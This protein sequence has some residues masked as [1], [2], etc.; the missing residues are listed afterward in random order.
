PKLD[1][2]AAI[3]LSNGLAPHLSEKATATGLASDGDSYQATLHALDEAVRNAVCVGADPNRLAILD[4]FCWP[5]CDDPYQLGSLVRAAEACYDGALVY[6][7]PFVSGK[8]SLSNQFTT[9][10]GR[11]I[12]ILP[13]LLITALGYLP[14]ATKAIT[15]D[16]KA[17]GHTL[18][19]VG[20]TTAHLGGSH[21][22]EL[23][24]SP[25]NP[26][27]R[28]PTVDLTA[29]PRHAAAVAHL[30]DQRLVA[31]AHDCSEGGLLPAAAEMAFAGRIGLALDL[32]PSAVPTPD[33][34]NP[35]PLV[36][37]AF[38]E[39]PSRYLLEVAPDHLDAALKH[40]EAQSIPHATIG[41]FNDSEALT[42]RTDALGRVLDTPLD[43]LR[44]AW[45]GTLDW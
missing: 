19:L 2:P 31:A 24:F 26:D 9:E 13:T 30:I 33:P 29:G 32:S 3:T 44:Q 6:Q 18:L 12:T 1:S 17:P 45:L 41:T 34:A 35:L 21:L 4:N 7:A 14:D 23:G 39:S 42:A 16:A 11:L 8:D 25:E 22:L 37:A 43:D 38:A 5:R 10:D 40:L 20:H 36:A 15:M 27:R 28:I